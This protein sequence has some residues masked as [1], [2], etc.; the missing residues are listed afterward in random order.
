MLGVCRKM[1]ISSKQTLKNN[2]TTKQNL[3]HLQSCGN[4]KTTPPHKDQKT[5]LK[6]PYIEKILS[7]V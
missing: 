6:H 2:A 7:I 4:S 3:L 5:N 1:H